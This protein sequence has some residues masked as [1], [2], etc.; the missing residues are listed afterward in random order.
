MELKYIVVRLEDNSEHAI[1]FGSKLEHRHVAAIHSASSNR[2]VM[3]AGFTAGG[4]VYG[5]SESLR[6]LGSRPQDAELI[7]LLGIGGSEI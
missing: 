2:I 3:S 4:E 7:R 1:V 6:G 5:Y